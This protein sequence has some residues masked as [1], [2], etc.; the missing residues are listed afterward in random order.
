MLEEID[1]E[2]LKFINQFD[3]VPKDKILDVFPENKFSTSFRISYLE[4][5][6]YKTSEYGFKFP[7]ENTNYIESLYECVED[8]N[9]M[10]NSIKLDIYYLTDLGKSFIQNH[11]RESINKRKAIRQEFFKSILQN[12]FCPIIVSVITTLIT[13]WLITKF[14][15]PISL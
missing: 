14:S 4:E 11:I 15:L 6:E 12:V 2:I 5:K 9:G 8:E 10:T 7:I 1:I 3:N 13:Y